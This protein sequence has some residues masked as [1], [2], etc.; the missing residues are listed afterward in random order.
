MTALQP[1]Y[2]KVSTGGFVI[3]D[4]YGSCPPCKRAIDDFRSERGI[5]AALQVIDRQSVFWRKH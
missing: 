3:V 4:D 5:T 2:D 1:L